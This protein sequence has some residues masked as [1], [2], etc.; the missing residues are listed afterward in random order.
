LGGQADYRRLNALANLVGQSWAGMVVADGMRAFDYLQSRPEVDLDR[1]GVAGMG[2]AGG[3]AMFTAAL[4]E[5][6]LAVVIGDYL[7]R[8]DYITPRG[9]RYSSMCVAGLR[10]YAET[11]DIGALIAPRP[12]LYLRSETGAGQ[13]K[14]VFLQIARPYELLEVPDRLKYQETGPGRLFDIDA[15]AVWFYRWL[16]EED[17]A[18][19]PLLRYPYRLD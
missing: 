9:P 15:A 8:L 6:V 16:I 1:L 17:D 12:A 3:L 14:D 10:R 5:R 11:A 2:M 18:H 4:D 19:L 7:M 13:D